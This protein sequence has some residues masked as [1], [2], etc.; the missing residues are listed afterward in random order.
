[1]KYMFGSTCGSFGLVWFDF[2]SAL[3]WLN[4][5]WFGL[6]WSDLIWFGFI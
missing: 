1:M 2:V 4:L 6:N 3:I 5:I